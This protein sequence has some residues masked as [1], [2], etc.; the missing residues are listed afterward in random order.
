MTENEELKQYI[1][2]VQFLD[3]NT[4]GYL[5]LY[6]MLQGKIY[7]TDKVCKKYPLPSAEGKG[8]S[9]EVWEEIVYPG[10]RKQLEINLEEIRRGRQK[11]HD[12]E[13]RLTD[14]EGN[15]VW[16]KCRGTVQKNAEGHPW[17]LLGSVEELPSGRSVDTLTG[18]WNYDK[19]MEDMGNCL[20]QEDGYLMEL[21][22]DN[23]K[24]INAKN[25]RAFG[26]SILKMVAEVLE[27][28]AE[29]PMKLYRLVGDCF[30]VNF[31]RGKREDIP[32]FYHAV[33]NQL[34]K[35]CALSAGV[36]EYRHGYDI[37]PGVVYQ[38]VENTL[39]RAKHRGKNTLE[40]FSTEDYQAGLKQIVLLE[41]M[42]ASAENQCRGFYLCYQPQ[43]DSHDFSLYGAEALLR[44][45]SPSRGVV[46]PE[47]FI[48]LLEQNG[49]IDIVGAW[50]LRTAAFQCAKWRQIMPSF[51]MSV[52]I[53]YAQL[54]RKNI[55]EIV[56][57]TLQEAGIPGEALTLEVTESMQLQDYPYFNKI[58]Y[59]WRKH[60]IRIAIDDFGTGYSSLSYLKSI[61]VDET[62]IDRSFVNRIQYNAYNSKLLSNMI[63]LAHSAQIRVC[64][65]GVETEEELIALQELEA[66]TLQGFLFAKPYRSEEF[67][68]IYFEP[69]SRE[70]R[71][72]M[73]REQNFRKTGAEENR[74]FLE[75]LRKEELANIVE[76]MDEI[77]CVRDVDT[78][79]L[80]Y[81]NPAGRRATGMYDYKGRK[82]YQVLQGRD[83]PCE[84]CT[85]QDL[86]KG[87]ALISEIRSEPLGKRLLT[88]KKLIPWQGKKACLEIAVD[89]TGE[90]L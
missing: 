85:K 70:Y 29:Y 9:L 67:E 28:H 36:V 23:F 18:L 60:G 74:I 11:N 47:E 75:N 80:Y 41:E 55:T 27:S 52:N 78:Y 4:E 40:F 59:E 25:G 88:K 6:D 7:F 82:C 42:R 43:V 37:D 38:Y 24:N 61:D 39:D 89:I 76:A 51:H 53:S 19:F 63:E 81:L 79:D 44:Y 86:Q 34:K 15:C 2:M 35:Y 26:D 31:V 30:A 68:R 33:Q 69:E 66:D 22:I 16:I 54:R 77:I 50:V 58:F 20:K 84:C 13:Y 56:L 65:E 57:E 3:E 8:I 10:D 46:S 32:E 72:R 83:R 12:M 49:L 17:L 87:M 73:E 90:T 71:E 48:P 45:E 64:C 5:Y 1:R 21:G 62:K 14:R